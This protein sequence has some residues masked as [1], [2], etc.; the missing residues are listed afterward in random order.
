MPS[1]SNLVFVGLNALTHAE[2]VIIDNLKQKD[3]ARVFWDADKYYFNESNHEA[4]L[5]L[6]KQQLKWNEV[7]FVGVGDY[8]SKPKEKTFM[9][10]LFSSAS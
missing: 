5:F 1:A 8:L 9:P 3:I 6:K 7:D 4:G 10:F 2:H